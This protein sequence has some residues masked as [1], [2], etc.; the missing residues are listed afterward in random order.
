MSYI[1]EPPFSSPET[2][3]QSLESIASVRGEIYYPCCEL[4]YFCFGEILEYLYR[5]LFQI[6]MKLNHNLNLSLLEVFSY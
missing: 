2:Y 4:N 3:S 6:L 5:H 1:S